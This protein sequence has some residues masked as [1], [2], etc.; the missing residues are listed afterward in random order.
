MLDR[1]RWLGA[2]HRRTVEAGQP[3][4]EEFWDLP[5]VLGVYVRERQLLSLEEAIRKMTS[6]NAAKIG[7]VD[8]GLLRPGQFA[9]ITLF[10]AGKIQDKSTYLEPFQYPEGIEYVIV[11][12]KP[13]LERGE[14][15]GSRPGRA[16]RHSAPRIE[17]R[18]P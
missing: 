2:R 16:L 1:F 9:D 15:N 13:V 6:L 4:P 8:R 14:H 10:D 18:S 7:I 12:G 3:T 11:N 5:R 17:L